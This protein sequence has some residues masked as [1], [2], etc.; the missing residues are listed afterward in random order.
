MNN[1][2]ELNTFDDASNDTN[3]NFE[4]GYQ[5]QLVLPDAVDNQLEN[6][7]IEG[8][9]DLKTIDNYENI[10]VISQRYSEHPDW[11]YKSRQEIANLIVLGFQLGLQDLLL[12]FGYK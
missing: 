3:Q 11:D 2:V 10:A 12:N 6:A 5:K 7:K 9:I 8:N 1:N 4:L